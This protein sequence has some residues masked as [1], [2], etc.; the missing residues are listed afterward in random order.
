MPLAMARKRGLV[1]LLEALV[2]DEDEAVRLVRAVPEL[3]RSRVSEGRFF[4][5][6]PHWVYVGDT[7]LHLAAAALKPAG[8]EA[9]LR[10]GADPNAENRRGALALHYACDPRPGSGKT[11]DPARQR[12]VIE[13]LLDAG[14]KIEHREKAGAAPLH[15]AVR[16]R[17]AEAVRCLLERGARVDARH[18]KQR[19]SPLHLALHSTGASGTKGARAE[20]EEIV[21]LLLEHG[22]NPRAKDAR[23]KTPPLGERKHGR[24]RLRSTPRRGRAD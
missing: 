1:D 17:S 19:S 24:D 8:V 4:E 13:L 14:S 11:W 9:L 2:E 7:A 16:A 21:A 22:A 20:Q 12:R 23:G 6:V 18:G 15:R 5:E 3:A 10:A